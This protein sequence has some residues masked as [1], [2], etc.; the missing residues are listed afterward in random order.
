[1]IDLESRA[2]FSRDVC[3]SVTITVFL[4]AFFNV[5]RLGV[6]HWPICSPGPGHCRIIVHHCIRFTIKATG[7][8]LTKAVN[9]AEIVKRRFVRSCIGVCL[10]AISLRVRIVCAQFR[11]SSFALFR[12]GVSFYEQLNRIGIAAFESRNTMSST[13]YAIVIAFRD[14]VFRVPRHYMW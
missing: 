14:G 5:S 1:M 13:F 12:S 7:N 8:A 4:L 11:R 9:L 3:K 2:G 10:G 6:H